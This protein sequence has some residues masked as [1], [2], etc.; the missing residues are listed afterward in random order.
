MDKVGKGLVYSAACPRRNFGPGAFPGHPWED[1]I[2]AALTEVLTPLVLALALYPTGAGRVEVSG[3]FSRLGGRGQLVEACGWVLNSEGT[4]SRA[5]S[6]NEWFCVLQVWLTD[7][8]VPGWLSLLISISPPDASS[9]VLSAPP[10]RQ[11]LVLI[12]IGVWVQEWGRGYEAYRAGDILTRSSLCQSFNFSGGAAH[13]ALLERGLC[14]VHHSRHSRSRPF[15]FL[16]IL[17]LPL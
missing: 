17:L 15:F 7:P 16:S 6:G 11:C 1:A 13:C 3:P 12:L 9:H 10:D 4:C 8:Q 2:P 14:C 5:A